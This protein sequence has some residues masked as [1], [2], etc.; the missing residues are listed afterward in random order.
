MQSRQFKWPM[1]HR[2]ISPSGYIQ[3]PHQSRGFPFP[4][5]FCAKG[6]KRKSAAFIKRPPEK[7]TFGGSRNWREQG[8]DRSPQGHTFVGVQPRY[9]PC[10]FRITCKQSR[11]EKRIV[12]APPSVLD[13]SRLRP[14]ARDGQLKLKSGAGRGI[15]VQL[16]E[17]LDRRRDRGGQHPSI[18]ALRWS[19]EALIDTFMNQ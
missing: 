5:S 4:D 9:V 15:P 19:Q 17:R 8:Q 6:T 18:F 3:F 13:E 10:N 11:R 1:C 12:N 7:T 14:S 16:S 2:G